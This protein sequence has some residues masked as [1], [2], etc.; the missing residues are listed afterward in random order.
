MLSTIGE[1][2]TEAGGKERAQQL[3]TEGS[4]KVYHLTGLDAV[5]LVLYASLQRPPKDADLSM[6][7]SHNIHNT[8]HKENLT[9][10]CKPPHPPLDVLLQD[11]NFL[12]QTLSRQIR[13]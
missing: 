8:T 7:H 4:W 5:C 12:Y 3:D 6:R 9:D 2:Q 1:I 13:R 11:M 10:E